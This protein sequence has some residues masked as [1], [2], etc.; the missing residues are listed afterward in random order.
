M[1]AVATS[2]NWY[3]A[4]AIVLALFTFGHTVGT[5]RPVT[6]APQERAVVDAMH[7]YHV[8]V[9]GFL[10]TYWEF[11][12]GFSVSISI[13]LAAL[14]VFAWQVGAL[15]QRNPREAIPLGATLLL[16]C[17]S[18]AIIS[19]VYFFTAPI[20]LSILAVICSGVALG[21]NVRDARRA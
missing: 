7:G 5:R 19:C 14:M 13:L 20:V 6:N 9:M 2:R 16:A 1:T 4:L 10:R 11:Y 18:Q 8:P 17:I 21:L 15:S 3:R 12:R